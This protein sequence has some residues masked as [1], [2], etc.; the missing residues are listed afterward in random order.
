MSDQRPRTTV[1]LCDRP[2]THAARPSEVLC[3][4]CQKMPAWAQR[5]DHTAQSKCGRK[6]VRRGTRL[7]GTSL[8]AFRKFPRPGPRSSSRRDIR[9]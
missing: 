9:E 3:P 2:P 6:R 4:P 8:N 5:T 7:R 1:G